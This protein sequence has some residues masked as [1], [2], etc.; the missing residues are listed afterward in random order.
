M[1]SR[2]QENSELAISTNANGVP[3][4]RSP[5]TMNTRA[6]TDLHKRKEFTISSVV[7]VDEEDGLEDDAPD[8]ELSPKP[9]DEPEWMDD[10][11]KPKNKKKD[12]PWNA[13]KEHDESNQLSMCSEEN[14]DIV[15]VPTNLVSPSSGDGDDDGDLSFDDDDNEENPTVDNILKTIR[16]RSDGIIDDEEEE[17]SNIL[18]DLPS[19][20]SKSANLV[21]PDDVAEA[22]IK[23]VSLVAERVAQKSDEKELMESEKEIEE[24]ERKMKAAAAMAAYASNRTG[25]YKDILK[26]ISESSGKLDL[27]DDKSTKKKLGISSALS[28]AK[29]S[30]QNLTTSKQNTQEPDER[31]TQHERVRA[32]ALKMLQLADKKAT[33]SNDQ[34]GEAYALRKTL[35]GGYRVSLKSRENAAIRGLGLEYQEDNR[36][37]IDDNIDYDDDLDDIHDEGKNGITELANQ[38][39]TKRMTEISI[40]EEASEHKK[41]SW[42]NRYSINH[43]MRAMHGGLT[44]KQVLNKMKQENF[45]TQKNTSATTMYKASPHD[46]EID[47]YNR[48]N[49]NMTGWNRLHKD[50]D[51]QSPPGRVWNTMISSVSRAFTKA[52]EEDVMT[53]RG[54]HRNQDHSSPKGKNIFTAI[55]LGLS[56]ASRKGYDSPSKN[57]NSSDWRSI[58]LVDRAEDLPKNMNFTPHD[59]LMYERRQKR[60]KIFFVASIILLL[61]AV[62]I[63]VVAGILPHRHGRDNENYTKDAAFLDVGESVQF[64]IISD[65]PYNPA[66]EEKLRSDISALR[67]TDGDFFIH[68][69]DINLATVTRCNVGVYEDAGSILKASPVPVVV[70]PGNNDWNDCPKPDIAFNYWMEH[71]NRFEEKFVHTPLLLGRQLARDENFAFLRKGVLFI[72]LNLVDG[73]VQSEDEWS[74]RHLDNVHWV[75]KNLN[76]YSAPDYRAIVILGHAPPNAK[77]G[78]FFWPILDDLRQIIKPVLYIHANNG[79]QMNSYHPFDQLDR[80][81]AIELPRGS[82]SGPVRIT[83]DFGMAPFSFME[84]SG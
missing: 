37:S 70:L 38:K 76:L 26:D 43:H 9:I 33:N 65:T 35:S 79:G 19:R 63:G 81:T 44:S 5:N 67:T 56:P 54:S 15:G 83:I 50:R 64:Y 31:L 24:Q 73:T 45:S 32:E 1:M 3:S 61:L 4:S 25:Q 68:L 49:W 62:V 30:V 12:H 36:F 28:L 41:N 14:V 69:G 84:G 59:D 2:E 82:I 74:R 23:G 75:E 16:S 6:P 22:N 48:N 13:C 52:G 42:S 60:Q 8:D 18:M 78:D 21:C 55:R 10:S 77:V 17:D 20:W 34:P 29:N 47:E 51:P 40:E 46:E 7:S 80:M 66:D 72:G 71:M 27:N 57:E 39:G 11:N 58:N 53:T